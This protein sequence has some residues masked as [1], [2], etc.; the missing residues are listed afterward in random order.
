VTYHL[1][2]LGKQ[3]SLHA[4]EHAS[5]RATL[6]RVTEGEKW[7]SGFLESV[8]CSFG[9]LNGMILITCTESEYQYRPKCLGVRVK[10]AI[11]RG[12]Q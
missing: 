4:S 5:E 6:S 1:D 3:V 9:R 12:S 2:D 7:E 8:Y 11:V 10:A